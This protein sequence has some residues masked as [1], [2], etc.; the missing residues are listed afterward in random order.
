[1]K[2]LF[3]LTERKFFAALSFGVFLALSLACNAANAA[4]IDYISSD[5]SPSA[6]YDGQS[7]NFSVNGGDIIEFDLTYSIK[8]N[9]STA[10]FPRS[11][12]FGV[13]NSNPPNPSTPDVT[14]VPVTHTFTSASSSFTDHV[15][16]TAPTTPG[17]YHVDIR[18][19][20]GTAN[21][22]GGLQGGS[23]IVIQF[24]VADPCLSKDTAL[25]LSLSN[26]CMLYHTASTIFT[27]TLTSGG[28][29]VS[30][31][32]I[33]FKVDEVSVG[34]AVTNASGVATLTYDPSALKVGDHTVVASFQGAACSYNASGNSTTLGVKYLF[35]G[36]Q[37]PINAD[38]SSIFKGAT[39]P[40]KVIIED[41]NGALVP[42]AE[43]H[44]FFYFNTPVGVGTD[45][46]P[47]ANTNGDT[48]NT[49]RY[50]ASAG[51]YIFNWDT[52]NLGNG[53]YTI[54]VGLGEGT[55]ADSHTVVLSINKKSSK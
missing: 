54:R 14:G 28:S 32:T 35:L 41:A 25:S 29:A 46:E 6:K 42:D 27:A 9:G 12:E 20:S 11:V 2:S 26:P 50:D 17:H 45:A 36:F 44:L 53:T 5:V 55:C 3:C 1:M 4:S 23:G 16:I 24:V 49:M 43:A 21:G 13:F 31:E 15:K 51:Q 52:T 18:A 38:G 37:Q 47:V 34:S 22:G 33:D 40:V 48:G 19:L 10:S 7:G 8:T 39:I 30:G